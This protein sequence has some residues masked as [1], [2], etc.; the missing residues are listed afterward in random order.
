MGVTTGD[1]FTMYLIVIVAFFGLAIALL[2][3]NS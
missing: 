1:V 3:K 2:K